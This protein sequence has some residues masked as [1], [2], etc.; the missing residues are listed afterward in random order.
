MKTIFSATLATNH[1]HKVDLKSHDEISH[2][3]DHPDMKQF[4]VDSESCSGRFFGCSSSQKSSNMLKRKKKVKKNILKNL[5]LI[6]PE[7]ADVTETF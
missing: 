1:L 3:V 4:N 5:A 7:V 2:S 6:N